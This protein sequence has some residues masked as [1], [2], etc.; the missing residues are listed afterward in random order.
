MD[1]WNLW[2]RNS[3]QHTPAARSN[4]SRNVEGLC[5]QGVSL[6]RRIDF[7]EKRTYIAK[8]ISDILLSGWYDIE[9]LSFHILTLRVY[10]IFM[11]QKYSFKLNS[12]VTILGQLDS[13]KK[14]TASCLADSLHVTD[15]TIYRYI[16][17]LQNAGYPIFFDREKMSYCFTDGFT[18]NK[19]DKSEEFLA[20]DLKSRM[21]GSSPVG[22][23]SYDSSGQ[24]V[25]ANETAAAIV[26]CSREQVLSQNYVHLESW[27]SSGLLIMA[28]E[29]MQTGY[30]RSGDI[31]VQTT[32]GK[33]VWL[34]CNMSRFIQNGKHFLHLV[35]QDITPRKMMEVALKENEDMFR[36]FID[37]SPVYTFIKDEMLRFIQVS[38]NYET[39]LG[40]PLHQII[41]KDMSELFP[42]EF[43]D[44]MIHDDKLVLT[45]GN[46]L[47][48]EEHFEGS[49]FTT[50]KFPFERGGVKY[51]A[52]YAI[53]ITERKNAEKQLGVLAT[54]FRALA[55]T[56]L[57]A[58]WIVSESG[59]IIEVNEKACELYGYTRDALLTMNIRDIEADEDPEEIKLHLQKILE[60]GYDRFEAR[61]RR[62][63]GTLIEVE[64]SSARIP[65]SNRLLTFTRDISKVKSTAR[66]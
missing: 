33:Y 49:Y 5:C 15:R 1:D 57:D 37:N 62:A 2:G 22:L 24:C 52:G 17:T 20:L 55:N 8:Y 63:D 61:Q 50:I 29:V 48:L 45:S 4:I 40:K 58:F 10:V 56:T 3:Q 32:G 36:L 13:G 54:Q 65:E 12:L 28:Q 11:P 16:M 35:V 34:N 42:K 46:R 66:E 38:R 25:V 18:L 41:G 14:I 31:H 51:I 39:L 64:V 30:E 60:Q 53:D 21:L 23:L 6:L 47:E 27:K 9:Q 19:S 59:K 44:T 7:Y 26:G 43:A